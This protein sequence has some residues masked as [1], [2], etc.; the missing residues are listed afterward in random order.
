MKLKNFFDDD[1][2]NDLRSKMG[3]AE[4]IDYNPGVGWQETKI[5]SELEKLG[6]VEVPFDLLTVED[7]K[8]ITLAG[9]RVLV[10]IRDQHARY[11]P[12]Y[13][14]H[15]ANCRTLVDFQNG[16]RFE[17]F[18]ASIRTDGTFKVNI[19]SE[20]GN[21]VPNQ[22]EEL[23]VCKNCLTALN[24]KGYNLS[25][26]LKP[27]IFRDF[28][29]D[30]FFRLYNKQKIK[31]PT[32]SDVTAPLN[33]YPDNWNDISYRYKLMKGFRCEECGIKLSNTP[34]LLH[35]HHINGLKYDCSANNLKALC[36]SC[37]AH[38]PGHGHMFAQP[39]YNKFLEIYGKASKF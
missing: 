23:S 22:Y 34:K 19:I 18:V 8:T 25:Y 36:T 14:F 29:L 12:N 4:L 27:K 28:D 33:N 10:Y 37:H 39:D 16:G 11:Y 1:E 30:E 15:L 13:R 20:D 5:G 38:Q 6:E 9:R 35:T 24:Y 7:D 17:K 2:L 26:E 31:K 21:V 3:G 32:Q